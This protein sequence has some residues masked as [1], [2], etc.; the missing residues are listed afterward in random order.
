MEEK[1]DGKVLV[2]IFFCVKFCSFHK[3]TS[4]QS[5]YW[6]KMISVNKC[7]RGSQSPKHS[8]S[9]VL[10]PLLQNGFLEFDSG[11]KKH[12][13]YHHQTNVQNA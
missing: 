11:H 5:D 8:V 9:I 4:E 6:L 12:Q 13:H 7:E 10:I 1:R 2:S 3:K